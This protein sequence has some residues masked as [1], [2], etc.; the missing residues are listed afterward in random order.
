MDTLLDHG[1]NIFATD[2]E[3]KSALFWAAAN[4]HHDTVKVLL[5]DRRSD[6]LL[7][8][9]DRRN[10]TPLHVAAQNGFLEVAVALLDANADVDVK[11]EDEESPLHLAAKEGR[12]RYTVVC[13][14][15]V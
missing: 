13:G 15:S 6:E 10:N 1:A 2:R 8:T 3:D 12:N 14:S 4:N 11:N 5:K 9:G 7:E